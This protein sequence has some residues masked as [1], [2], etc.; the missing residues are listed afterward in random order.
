MTHYGSAFELEFLSYLN[1]G[2]D[3]ESWGIREFVVYVENDPMFGKV[4]EA[5]FDED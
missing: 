4:V 2:A 5:N 1:E 3:N